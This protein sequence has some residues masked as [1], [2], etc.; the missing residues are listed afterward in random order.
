M[1]AVGIILK[2][3]AV[4]LRLGTIIGRLTPSDGVDGRW[5]DGLM[6]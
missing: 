5:N 2:E 3:Y 1:E 4:G 6:D